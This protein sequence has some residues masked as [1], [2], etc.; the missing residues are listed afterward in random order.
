MVVN[1][2]RVRKLIEEA[3]LTQ[4]DVSRLIGKSNACVCNVIQ[5]GRASKS[6]VT[7]LCKVL[8]VTQDVL[9][10][11]PEGPK[12]EPQTVMAAIHRLYRRIDDLEQKMTDMME[13]L[14]ILKE[15]WE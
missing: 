12:E 1:G 10:D 5:N 6:T 4:K 3:G 2:E 9:T 13:T 7:D 14:N 15:A 8:R 11:I